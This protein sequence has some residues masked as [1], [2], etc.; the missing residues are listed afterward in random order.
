MKRDGDTPRR[1]APVCAGS[2]GW[3]RSIQA[4]PRFCDAGKKAPGPSGQARWNGHG[5]PIEIVGKSTAYAAIITFVLEIF[6]TVRVKWPIWALR[7]RIG[8]YPAGLRAAPSSIADFSGRA[9]ADYYLLERTR[10]IPR[11]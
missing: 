8:I 2:I 6:Q 11:E 3:R 5:R 4:L 9:V 7:A 1:F 10:R